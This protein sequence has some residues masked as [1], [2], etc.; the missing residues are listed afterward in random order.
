MQN[1][2]HTS[3][4]SPLTWLGSNQGL[5]RKVALPILRFMHIE[6]AGG[7][8]LVAV[9]AVALVVA[10]SPLK[11]VYQDFLHAHISFS[12]GD[13]YSL[14]LPV[15]KWVNDA[16]MVVFFF[17]VGLEIKRELVIGEL[18]QPA[19]ALFPAVAA[20]GGMLVPAAIYAAFN[21]GGD[22]L[23]GWG[24]PMATDI[25]FALGVVSLLG[26]KVSRSMKI[27]LL[28]VAVVDDIG[29]ILVIAVFYTKELKPE[30][31]VVALAV[32]G[33]LLLMRAAGI[34]YIPAYLVAGFFLWLAIFESG[35]HAT[36]A[37][38]I[39]GVLTPAKPLVKS[40]N[41]EQQTVQEMKLDSEGSDG[42][43]VPFVKRASFEVRERVSVL[44]RLEDLLHPWTSFAIVPI[45]ALV[46]AGVVLSSESLS[47]AFQ[48][49]VTFGVIAGLVIGKPVGIML[50]S[51]VAVRAGVC[52]LPS[53]V[54]WQKIGALSMVAGIG[55]TVSLFIAKLAFT[56]ED[57]SMLLV[58]AKIGVLSASAIATL[59]GLA[60]LYAFTAKPAKQ[61]KSAKQ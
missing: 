42:L 23:S 2:S 40:Q 19:A 51:W 29:A 55:F 6:T 8:V 24:V 50:F 53:G 12:I 39:L 31:L 56:G 41:L 45:F 4:H 10:N 46:N 7:F 25:A 32:V 43:S 16:L 35:V 21:L 1:N 36:I 27:F 44:Q 52:S 33:V 57:G 58:N 9:T 49:S 48:S 18:R 22:G 38:V 15:E 61:Q 14:D 11:D 28:S 13:F 26:N 54:N 34:W 37:G 5:A 30:W 59:L 17:V 60:A 3:K 47:S 20:L